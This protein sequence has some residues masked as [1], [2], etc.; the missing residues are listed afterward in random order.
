MTIIKELNHKYDNV[1]NQYVQL[2]SKKQDLTFLFWLADKPGQ[3]AKFN[4][5][6]MFDFS[7]IKYDLE[8][9]QPDGKIIEWN[10]LMDSD[11]TMVDYGSFCEGFY[12]PKK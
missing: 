5:E 3:I 11:P 7:N 6:Y 8:T 1:V 10:K 2:F 4:G 9:G 12:T